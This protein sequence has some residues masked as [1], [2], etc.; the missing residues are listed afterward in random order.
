MRQLDFVVRLQGRHRAKINS[1]DYG[2]VNVR[3]TVAKN[4][5]ED[6]VQAHV[7]PAIAFDVDYLTTSGFAVVGRPL[8][9][10]KHL[11]AFT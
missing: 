7:D 8:V 6:S 10:R 1:S 9:R 4:T 5:S 2:I 11:R 3:I